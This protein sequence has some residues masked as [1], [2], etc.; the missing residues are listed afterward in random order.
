MYLITG[1]ARASGAKPQRSRSQPGST[2]A[3]T[4]TPPTAPYD[5]TDEHNE[6]AGSGGGNMDIDEQDLSGDAP[7]SFDEADL[8]D[9]DL[10]GELE[11][12]R[13]DMGL[14]SPQTKPSRASANKRPK[15]DAIEEAAPVVAQFEDDDRALETVDVTEEDMND[16]ALLA[17]LSSFAGGSASEQAPATSTPTAEPKKQQQQPALPPSTPQPSSHMRGTASTK[18][19][20]AEGST[21]LATLTERQAELK[22]AALIAKRQ[23]NMDRAREMLLHM[24]TAQSAVQTLRSGQQLPQGFELPP[25][26]TAEPQEPQPHSPIVR[27]SQGP[28]PATSDT[29]PP[30]QSLPVQR[31][32][33]REPAA[34]ISLPPVSQSAPEPSPAQTT[35]TATPVR[36]RPYANQTAVP[37]RA[38]SA[39]QTPSKITAG[40]SQRVIAGDQQH[41]FELIALSFTAMKSKLELQIAQATRLSAYFLKS[42]NKQQALEFHRLKKR[43]AADIATANYRPSPPPFLHKE[44][45]WTAPVEQRRDISANELQIAVKRVVSDGDLAATLGGQSDFYIQWEVAWPRDKPSKAY[46]RTIKFKELE[47]NNG[48]LDIDYTHS[49]EIIDRQHPRPLQR[50][51]ERGRLVIEFYKYGGLLWGSQLIGKAALPLAEL[52]TCSEA[53][54]MVEIKAGT[55]PLSRSAKSLAGGPLYIDVA[56]RLRL[57]L[58]N[59]A[60]T[61][62]HVERWIYIDNEPPSQPALTPLSAQLPVGTGGSEPTR[63]SAPLPSRDPNQQ[64]PQTAS[65]QASQQRSDSADSQPQ[66]ANAS[67]S[68]ASN[69]TVVATNAGD[70]TAF[71]ATEMETQMDSMDGLMS[72]AV[73][74]LELMQ[75]PARIREVKSREV[76]SQ[77][78]ELEASIKLRMSVVAAQV[79]AGTLT[80]QDYMSGVTKELAAAKEWALAAKKGQRKDLALRALK[81]V[82]AMQNELSEM[83]AAMDAGEAAEE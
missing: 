20:G 74:E 29:G 22:S 67:V 11:A 37:R 26:P 7:D 78:Q 56:A 77:L 45:Q 55:D 14:S 31:Q 1:R 57:P 9:P 44:I 47:E 34:A 75:I 53:T 32:P 52:R 21:M 3:G 79:G 54:A 6:T 35:T 62:T 72:N 41:D 49:V 24:K 16:P 39:P 71:D 63:S 5:F 17:E 51:V 80:I 10:L 25:K 66:R 83:A 40:H 60:E 59:T 50:W 12:L 61:A 70:A 81:R 48:E 58:S 13:A 38:P 36:Q 15:A 4:G 8:N 73:L 23:G 18:G 42:G 82:K 33:P 19:S 64:P 76:A 43:A 2:A 68:M 69:T 46:T 28:Y 30:Q 27:P 65:R